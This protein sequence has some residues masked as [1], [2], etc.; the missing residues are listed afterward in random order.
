MTR[1]EFIVERTDLIIIDLF[2]HWGVQ[3]EKDGN[4]FIRVPMPKLACF[5]E[6]LDD[7]IAIGMALYDEEC[8]EDEDCPFPEGTYQEAR[9]M[10][11]DTYISV[12]T[13]RKPYEF[14]G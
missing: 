2:E 13:A 4:H 10:I 6:E 3:T 12:I 11:A 5:L 14:E 1:Y 9:K 8:F 7:D